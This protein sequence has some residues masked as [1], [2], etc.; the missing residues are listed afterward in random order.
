[1]EKMLIIA[2]GHVH[3]KTTDQA[4]NATRDA[5]LA[6]RTAVPGITKSP[7]DT[8]KEMKKAMRMRS[9]IKNTTIDERGQSIPTHQQRTS[10]T[11]LAASTMHI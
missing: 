4:G 7:Q 6:T 2:K 3:P 5:D 11:D 1:M 8:R 9:T 10:F